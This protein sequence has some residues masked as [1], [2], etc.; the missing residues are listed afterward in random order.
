MT[1]PGNSVP[2]RSRSLGLLVLGAFGISF[3]PVL[4]KM[5]GIG[6]MGPTAIG[7]WRTLF[8]AVSLVLIAVLSGKAKQLR[9]PRPVMI[10]CI[11]TGFFFF[12]DL[13]VWHR[14]ILYIGSGMSTVLGNTQVFA[15]SILCY[16]IFKEKLTLRFLAAATAGLFGV[17]LLV[18]VLSEE[19]VFTPDYVKGVILGLLTGLMYA[20]YIVGIKKAGSHSK[21][22]APLA[23]ITWI[24]V[25]ATFFLGIGSIFEE[26]TFLP[27]D[28]EAV[29]VLL[30]LGVVIQA[31]AWWLITYAMRGVPVHHASLILLLQPVLAV[32]WG[33][34]FFNELLVLLQIIGAVI[35][36]TA[37]YVG[38]LKAG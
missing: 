8:G 29:A 14:S 25:S 6:V 23:V 36:I 11:F 31:L 13:S 9:V 35:T 10:W 26:G 22:P 1:D 33:Y 5:L 17:V 27:P 7:F 24:C 20:M 21:A 15:S 32:L 12:L 30:G 2:S 3:S 18:G 28:V 37:V 16:Y 19:V 4:V 34:L 38:S